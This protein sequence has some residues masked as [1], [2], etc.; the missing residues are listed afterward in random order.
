MA[1]SAAKR[2]AVGPNKL[3]YFVKQKT[4]LFLRVSHPSTHLQPEPA[5]PLPAKLAVGGIAGIIGTSVI[6]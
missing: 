5:V 6:L 2:R 1:S 3:R 4:P